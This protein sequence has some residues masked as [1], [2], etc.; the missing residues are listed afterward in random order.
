MCSI[1]DLTFVQNKV[2]FSEYAL[3]NASN[4]SLGKKS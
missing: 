1:G 3:T 4:V 2:E